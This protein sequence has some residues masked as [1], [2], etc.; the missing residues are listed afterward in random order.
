MNADEHLLLIALGPVQSFIAQARRTRDLWYGSHLLSELGRAAARHLLAGGAELIFPALDPGH[1]ELE[2]CFEPLRS[3]HQPP[4]NVANKLLAR[5]P[6]EVDPEQLARAT[7]E[8]V[9]R[10]WR[11]GLA[12][13]VWRRCRP[14]LAPGVRTAWEEQLTTFLEFTAAWVPLAD[15]SYA[16]ARRALERT[17]AARKNLRDFSPWHHLRGDVPK[18]S[19]DG[20]RETVLLRLQ[21]RKQSEEAIGLAHRY[22]IADGEQLDAVGLVKRA[23][24]DPGQFVPV[25]NVA[26]AS[27]IAVAATVAPQELARLHDACAALGVARVTRQV[28][29]TEHFGFDASVLLPSRW[30]AAFQEQGLPDTPQVWGEAHVR[31]LLR[32][33]S[34][35]YP[36]VA[37]LV[38]DGDRM[39]K[40]LDRLES[41]E[42]HR[43]FSQTLSEFAAKARQIVEGHLGSLV[44]AGGDDVLAF[45]PLPT[46]LDCAAALHR[47]FGETMA[48]AGSP[49]GERPTLSVGIG[50]G[51][52][53]EGMDELL[54][55]GREAERIAK[56]GRGE[57]DTPRDALAVVVDLRSGGKRSWRARWDDEPTTR[58]Q[59]AIVTLDQGLPSRKVYEVA[60]T[61][62][63]LPSPSQVG[64]GR[65]EGWAQALA[66]EVRRSLAR[67][68]G[69]ERVEPEQVGLDLG[70]D[71][72]PYREVH[73]RVSAWVERMLVAR[74]FAAARPGPRSGGRDTREGAA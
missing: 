65:Q 10:F 49:A 26:L 60:R 53:M 2:P 17:V 34:E 16:E 66:W 8:E 43:A 11:D 32:R 3:N 44:Y 13:Q 50:V 74:S 15:R 33:M 70:S 59:E 21:D 58:L 35:P 38:A 6:A 4:L 52:V 68:R 47:A 46:A 37:C 5:V 18:S 41:S 54:G 73:R 12:E 72:L 42:A 63:Q 22:R 27:W 7:R 39:G 64:E 14:L 24:G 48:K 23:G 61:L 30:K 36:Y 57:E 25:V 71:D 51:H 69:E 31:P 62:R 67:V 20:E 40:A 55:L 45:L 1:P 19:L 9:Q 28:P 56:Q 29:A